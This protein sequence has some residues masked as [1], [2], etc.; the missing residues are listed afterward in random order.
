ML[1]QYKHVSSYYKYASRISS[2]PIYFCTSYELS[3]NVQKDV[4]RYMLFAD[5]KVLTD[6]KKNKSNT[7]LHLWWKTFKVK[8]LN[9]SWTTTKYME[10]KFSESGDE[11][12]ILW[13]RNTIKWPI[14][15]FSVYYTK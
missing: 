14:F 1:L 4:P 5:D 7:K 8:G 10:Y 11:G 3:T 12:V 15:L 6:V 2:K 13:P 9:I